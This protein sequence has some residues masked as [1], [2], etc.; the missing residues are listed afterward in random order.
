LDEVEW[1][2]WPPTRAAEPL[3]H[4]ADEQGA[5]IV[6]VRVSAPDRSL[7]AVQ[8]EGRTR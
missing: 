8:R 7:A 1:R 2:Q 3:L 4:L 5:P 6:L